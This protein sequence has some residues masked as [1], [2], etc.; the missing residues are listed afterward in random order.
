[1]I[2]QLPR[3]RGKENVVVR[4]D[5]DSH[6]AVIA[7]I[8]GHIKRSLHR[9]Q[10]EMAGRLAL[11]GHCSRVYLYLEGFSVASSTLAV[12]KSRMELVVR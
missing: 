7:L 10:R 2:V 1:M 3:A 8:G 12:T 6:R 4:A 5:S 11:D 9:A